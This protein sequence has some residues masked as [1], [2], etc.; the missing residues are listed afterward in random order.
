MADIRVPAEN[1]QAKAEF[2]REDSP[3]AAGLVGRLI[4]AEARNAE[5][6]DAQVFGWLER[7]RDQW[8]ARALAAEA[9]VDRIQGR[10]MDL[11]E[12]RKDVA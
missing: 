9:Q 3:E 11:L 7:E 10:M 6:R 4:D 2:A 1:G 5:L 8:K 12:I